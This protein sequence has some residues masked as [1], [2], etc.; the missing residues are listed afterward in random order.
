MSRSIEPGLGSDEAQEAVR[1]GEGRYHQLF[2]E[3]NDAALV[4]EVETGVIIEANREA[5]VLLGRRLDEIVGMHHLELHPPDKT[6]EY[7][8]MFAAHIEKGQAADFDAQVV[9]KDGTIV[10]VSISASTLTLHGKRLVVGLFRDMTEPKRA[11]AALRE[12]ETKHRTLVENLPQKIFFKDRNSVYISCNE[13]Y[14]RDLGL[15]PDEIVGRTDYDFYPKELAEKYRADDTRIMESAQAKEIEED[16]VQDG[17][18]AVVHTVKTPVTGENGRVVGIL[19]IFWDITEHKRAEEALQQAYQRNQTILDTSMDGFYV[20][21][22]DGAFG[23]CNEAFCELVG[24][25]REELL[26]MKIT[27]LEAAESPE[28]TSHHIERVRQTG[29]DR[30][31]TAHRRKDGAIVDLEISTT[32]VELPEESLFVCF[33]RD[34]TERKEGERQLRAYQQRLQALAT[35]LSSVEEQERRAIAAGLHDDISQTLA[36]CKMRMAGLD[37]S[38][39]PSDV[40]STSGEVRG[41]LDEA[42]NRTRSLTFQLSPPVLYEL[43]FVAAVE[44]LAEQLEEEHGVVFNIEQ[45]SQLPPID[46]EVSIVLFRAVRE[47]LINVIKHAQT[48]TARVSI[49]GNGDQVRVVVQDAGVGF[50]MAQLDSPGRPP[51]FG[52]FDIRE[53]LSYLGGGLQIESQPG[54]GTRV[55]MIVPLK[56]QEQAATDKEQ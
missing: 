18:Q 32:F 17:Q 10:P 28:E 41:L 23:D 30:F 31:E 2:N 42:I 43:G 14:A 34:V 16:Y 27:D 52:L 25:S 21:G 38:S 45:D 40:A 48:N 53:R 8:A 44:W 1:E 37:E 15:T 51:G 26:A 3:L 35:R 12:S 50:D 29:S 54:A 39:L 19:G 24:Y 5:E 55:A 4:A 36:L 47:L 22:L 9:K 7:R 49:D 33:A 6:K 56:L 13:S 46:D 11:E 20:L